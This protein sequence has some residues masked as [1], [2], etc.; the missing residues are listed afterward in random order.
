MIAIVLNKILQTPFAIQNQT[1]Q[2]NL[3]QLWIGIC[4]RKR[5]IVDQVI[6]GQNSI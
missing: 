2:K 3:M 1:F 4:T 5:E 6:K